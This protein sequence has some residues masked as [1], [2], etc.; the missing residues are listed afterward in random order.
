[1]LCSDFVKHAFFYDVALPVFRPTLYFSDKA[2]V[3]LQPDVYL[4]RNA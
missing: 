3:K 1:L 2:Q 4:R